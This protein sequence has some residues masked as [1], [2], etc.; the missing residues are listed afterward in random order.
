M[1][2][3]E[4]PSVLEI[5]DPLHGYIHLSELEKQILDLRATQRLRGV[6]S[7]AGVHLVF[8]GADC[9]LLGSLLGTLYVTEVFIE[10]L[11]GELEE[12]LKARLTSM[13][14]KLTKGPWA[15]VLDEYLDVRGFNRIRMANLILDSTSVSDVIENSTFSKNEI[16]DMIEKGVSI[17]GV[18]LK[19][20]NTPLNP[21]LIDEI[22]RDAYFA[23]VEYAQMEFRRLFT[24]TRIAKNKIAFER[25]ALFT[26]EAYLSAG[27]TMYDAVYFH[28]TV[29]AA[30]LLLL[31]ILDEAGS[32][33][34]PSPD[35]EIDEYL[36]YDDVSFHGILSKVSDDDS[37]EM[38]TA[39]SMFRDY[40]RRYL[41]K[42]AS[43]RAISDPEFLQKISTPDGLYAIES[44][45]A[46]DADIDPKNVYVDYPNRKSVTYYP[47]RIPLDDLVL[48]ERGTK[49]YEFWPL[50][51][52]SAIARSF[53]R[54][55]KPIRVYTSRGY[56]AKVKKSADKI[57]E[58]VDV[59]GAT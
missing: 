38:K 59:P 12:V 28:K 48:Y 42:H 56:R 11:G 23:G 32:Q 29:R 20:L 43:S 52:L 55:M 13:M 45:I 6:K 14:F 19:L 3:N 9:S 39:C 49:G 25:G 5:K 21:E 44:E 40:S 58:S 30:E 31:R 41:P 26:L 47:G 46:E 8:P 54:L 37:E 33:F 24:Q 1:T 7:P 22:E 57:L 35:K 34:L 15:N 2:L 16:S 51:E 36:D 17:K 50:T 18:R 10:Y 53:S 27:I 4:F